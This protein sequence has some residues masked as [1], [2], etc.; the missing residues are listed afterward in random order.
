M[1]WAAERRLIKYL[2][3]GA[4]T[5]GGAVRP[6]YPTPTRAACTL[7]AVFVDAVAQAPEALIASAGVC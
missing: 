2:P 1:I 4:V 3:V 7:R 6:V 5:G